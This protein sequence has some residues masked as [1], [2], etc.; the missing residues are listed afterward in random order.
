MEEEDDSN[1]VST[2]ALYDDI[3]FDYAAIKS[4]IFK[5][6][7]EEP[8]FWN[9]LGNV[10]GKNVLDLACGSGYYTRTIKQ[11]GA[12]SVHGI[13]QS[14]EMIALG[15]TTE[16]NDPVGVTYSSDD[17]GDYSGPNVDIVTA[18]YLLNYAKSYEQLLG[19]CKSASRPTAERFISVASTA[20]DWNP[21]RPDI[22]PFVKSYDK[23]GIYLEWE[24]SFSDGKET[25]I[26]LLSEDRQSRVSFSNYLWTCETIERALLESG[27]R[28][29]HW[30]ASDSWLVGEGAPSW[31]HIGLKEVQQCSVQFFVACK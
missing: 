21:Q 28:S 24:G 12:A 29:V 20:R 19:M 25:S 30:V 22:I 26:T 15:Q 7:I 27:F 16:K 3:V 8:T 23:C 31:L 6:W 11:R 5:K 2:R 14:S 17:A 9:V 1:E 13:D 10:N 18:Q 4:N